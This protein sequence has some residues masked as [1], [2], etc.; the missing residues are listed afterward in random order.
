MKVNELFWDYNECRW[1]LYFCIGLR[2]IRGV[3]GGETLFEYERE[4][5][6][7]G[8][9][10]ERGGKCKVLVFGEVIN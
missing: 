1:I 10:K 9:R 3:F 7:M 6:L 2:E 5:K 4:L 8:I